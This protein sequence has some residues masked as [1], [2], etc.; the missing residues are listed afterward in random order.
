MQSI[1]NF[2]E[3][4]NLAFYFYTLALCTVLKYRQ[5]L[6][7]YQGLCYC[8]VSK[9]CWTL[10]P[11]ELQHTRLPCPSLSPRVLSIE[12]VM[13]SNHLILSHPLLLPPVFPGIKAF[14]V[15]SVIFFDFF[16]SFLNDRYLYNT[17][18]SNW[19]YTHSS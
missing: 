13:L 2:I 4:K 5:L 1:C 3:G 18:K 14:A 15:S 17:V 16:F 9:S 19:L 8:S 6:L 7:A 10:W 12:S 11:H